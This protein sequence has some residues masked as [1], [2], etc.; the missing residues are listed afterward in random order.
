MSFAP[1]MSA[2]AVL[3]ATPSFGAIKIVGT[4]IKRS[5]GSASYAPSAAITYTAHVP[6]RCFSVAKHAAYSSDRSAGRALIVFFHYANN[7]EPSS[8]SGVTVRRLVRLS[9]SK[10]GTEISTKRRTDSGLHAAIPA[11]S[12]TPL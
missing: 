3:A 1:G 2:A 7:A 9:V 5:M 4:R 8:A 10:K 11:E 6:A 12:K